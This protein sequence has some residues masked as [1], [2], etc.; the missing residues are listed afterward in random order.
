MLKKLMG[1]IRRQSLQID[2]FRAAVADYRLRLKK[3]PHKHNWDLLMNSGQVR[4]LKPEKLE[5]FDTLAVVTDDGIVKEYLGGRVVGQRLVTPH[6]VR[7][8]DSPN[9]EE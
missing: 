9:W 2:W 6:F 1:S 8:S 4:N 3:Q 7:L 5:P